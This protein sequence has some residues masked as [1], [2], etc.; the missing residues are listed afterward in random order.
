MCDVHDVMAKDEKYARGVLRLEHETMTLEQ[1]QEWAQYVLDLNKLRMK[2][3]ERCVE[4]KK[5]WGNT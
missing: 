1:Q 2:H 4:C 3:I 5:E